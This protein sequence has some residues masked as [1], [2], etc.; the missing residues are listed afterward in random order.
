MLLTTWTS[1]PDQIPTHFG[2]DGAPDGWGSKS[3]LLFIPLI[4][5][6]IF[7][8]LTLLSRF[9]HIY[10]YPWKLTGQNAG[11]QYL[12]ARTFLTAIK[13]EV[14]WLFGFVEYGIVQTAAG[15]SEGLGVSILPIILLVFFGTVVFY[16]L[17]AWQAR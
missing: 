14:I 1:L 17:K 11:T 10:N 3:T 15:K 7:A 9:P 16:F 6:V 12:Y 13:T 4:T 5:T 2:F 8:A